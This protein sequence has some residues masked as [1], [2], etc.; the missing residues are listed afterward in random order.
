M[1]LLFTPVTMTAGVDWEKLLAESYTSLS[2]GSHLDLQ[3][4]L[5]PG[6]TI[7]EW[8]YHAE[9]TTFAFYELHHSLRHH[10]L[11]CIEPLLSARS[12]IHFVDVCKNVIF[13]TEFD[14]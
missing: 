3:D 11:T 10:H 4:Q 7:S 14:L 8:L 6:L 5:K 12:H 9:N 2:T 13:R 1:V